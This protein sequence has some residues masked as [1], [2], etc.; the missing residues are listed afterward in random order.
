[1]TDQ[2]FETVH[3]PDCIEVW[4]TSWFATVS[5]RSG[6]EVPGGRQRPEGKYEHID[7]EG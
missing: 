4:A 3:R 6:N 5:D 2:P 7:N 1:M